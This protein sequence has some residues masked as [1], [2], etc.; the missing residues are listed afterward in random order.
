MAKRLRAWVK[1]C[2]FRIDVIDNIRTAAK[3]ISEITFYSVHGQFNKKL[4]CLVIPRIAESIPNELFPHE[5]IKVPSNIRLADSQFHVPR[6]IDLLIGSGATL[7]LFSI[8]QF[9]LSHDECDLYAQKTLIGSVIVGELPNKIQSK[10]ESCQLANFF[11][12]IALA[13]SAKREK[14]VSDNDACETHYKL[15]TPRNKEERYIVRLPF[16]TARPQLSNSQM[17]A[18]R[19][20]YALMRKL[21][22]NQIWAIEYKRVMQEY[23]DTGHMTLLNSETENG[24]YLPHHAVIKDSLTTKVRVVF[25]A[26]AKGEM[27]LSLNDLLLTGPVIQDNI[28]EHLVRI[29][30]CKYMITA[31]IE[32]MYR[33]ILID[34]RDRCYQKIL[35]LHQ[36][37]IR[38]FELNTVTFGVSSSSFL[39]IRTL[40]QFAEDEGN[41][42]PI[43]AE[44][45][46][47]NLYVDDLLTGAD[48]LNEILDIRNELIALLKLGGFKIRKW[49]SNHPQ[50][51]E[52]MDEKMSDIQFLKDDTIEKNKLGVFWNATSDEFS[53]AVQKS[54]MSS[55][56]TKRNILSSV[57][58]IFDPLGLLG[59]VIFMA[60]LIVQ[61][62]WKDKI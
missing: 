51:V 8:G 61:E 47:N 18:M 54:D 26:S 32:K 52:F 56:I 58:K 10:G 17:I 62:C 39:A 5:S 43:G 36:N 50:A 25:D 59:P 33:Q 44:V 37:E 6:Q 29:R 42:F 57:A 4:T 16:K 49:A 48:T 3:G 30:L 15:N 9:K 1:P 19:R 2:E 45:L 41:K 40:K 34:E 11:N 27:G 21:K 31:D 53:Y 38:T 28:F 24:Y 20:F 22:G 12:R 60:K 46:K 14:I 23:I 35:W 55:K 7:S 13:S